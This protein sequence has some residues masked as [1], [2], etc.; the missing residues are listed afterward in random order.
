MT[1]PPRATAS[2]ED[3]ELARA[4]TAYDALA[5]RYDDLLVQNPV[6]AHSARVSEMLVASAMSTRRFL[7]EI[8]CGTGR[9]TLKLAA[10]GKE[11][12]AC[13]PSEVS[14]EVLRRKAAALGLSGLI[15][16]RQLRASQVS[17]LV[18]DFGDHAFEGAF[19]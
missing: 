18:R 9:E 14:I 4:R 7:L 11:I 5:P 8:G 2:S 10:M 6:L 3:D 13:D 12:V 1:H 17:D 15:Q 19:S 16:T